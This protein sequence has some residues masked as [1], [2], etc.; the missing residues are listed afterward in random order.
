MKFLCLYIKS[1]ANVNLTQQMEC[2]QNAMDLFHVS[3]QEDKKHKSIWKCD[4][5]SR[6]LVSNTFRAHE[7][8]ITLQTK[9]LPNPVL[10]EAKTSSSL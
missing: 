2:C 6:K 1:H 3:I 7:S 8:Q 5:L 9:H 4:G 10:R